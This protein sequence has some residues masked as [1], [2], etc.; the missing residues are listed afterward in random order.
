M[1]AIETE[2]LLEKLPSNYLKTLS[3]RT[4]YTRNYVYLVL[5]GERNNPDIL[6][7]AI[8]LADEHQENLASLRKK[9]HS[10]HR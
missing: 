9:I 6:S 4:K 7:A 8:E 1:D 5:R 2:I 3:E 10:L